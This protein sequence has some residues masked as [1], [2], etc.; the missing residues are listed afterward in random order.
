[1]ATPFSSQGEVYLDG[2]GP[3]DPDLLTL[4]ALQLLQR[5][6]VVLY[7][8][9]VSKEVLDLARRDAEFISVG[10]SAGTKCNSQESINQLLVAHAE[11][12]KRVC[13]LKGGDPFIFGRGGEELQALVNAGI[14]FQVVPGITAAS[15][16]ASYAGIPLTHR[17]YAQAAMFVTAHGKDSLDKLDWQALAGE[18][19]TLVFYM[20]IARIN[21]VQKQ[22]IAHGRDP[23]TPVAIVEN[24][25]LP[26]Q[27]VITGR[28]DSLLQLTET[29]RIKPPAI[30]IVG[31]VARLA[32]QFSWF[33]KATPADDQLFV[34][35]ASNG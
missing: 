27:R 12:G 25:T 28:L 20:G 7:D 6:D 34:A 26:N 16:C 8:R 32:E 3:G 9:L 33:N 15:G 21:A 17:E 11:Q 29:H 30:L 18:K 1:K 5:A 31:E 2:A 14:H 13:R 35:Q 24:G 19:Q 22:M 4:R 10:K 23:G